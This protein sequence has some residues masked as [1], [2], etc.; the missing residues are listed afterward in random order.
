[1]EGL[2]PLAPARVPNP[3]I[4]PI[5]PIWTSS[6][7]RDKRARDCTVASLSAATLARA[8]GTERGAT[9]LQEDVEGRSERTEPGAPLPV[10]SYSF[11]R[12]QLGIPFFLR[13]PAG[14][15]ARRY[16][17]ARNL[18]VGIFTDYTLPN[19]RSS[20]AC[21]H[22]EFDVRGFPSFCSPPTFVLQLGW[23]PP[24]SSF[25]ILTFLQ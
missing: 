3:T 16:R 7:V 1:M 15:A 6:F 11:G 25:E 8:P 10:L 21:P 13:A 24:P 18:G 19:V 14:P 20:I 22:S 9:H 4:V 23:V 12:Q 17:K 5:V 2:N